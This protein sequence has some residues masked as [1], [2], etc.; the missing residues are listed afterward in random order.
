MCVCV[1]V[2]THACGQIRA[3]LTVC[4]CVCVCVHACMWTDQGPYLRRANSLLNY[5]YLLNGDNIEKDSMS[6]CE[7]H[8]YEGLSRQP[9]CV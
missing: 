8:V 3:W 1:C 5:I 7:A 9:K 6:V 2:C 4:V